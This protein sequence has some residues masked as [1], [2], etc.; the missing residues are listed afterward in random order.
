MNVEATGIVIDVEVA[1][2]LEF[3]GSGVNVLL[4]KTVELDLVVFANGL[5]LE[6]NEKLVVIEGFA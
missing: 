1:R 5:L 4:P 2:T 3:G 6:P